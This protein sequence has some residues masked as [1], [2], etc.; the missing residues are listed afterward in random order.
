MLNARQIPG[1]EIGKVVLRVE[2]KHDGIGAALRVDLD[3]FALAQTVAHVGNHR[4][5]GFKIDVRGPV[6][7]RHGMRGD[8]FAVGAVDHEEE[9]ILRFLDEI[10]HG[11]SLPIRLIDLFSRDSIG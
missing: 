7:A 10:L 8:Q 11:T 6:D 2:R 1:V 3:F 9:T 5:A 4:A